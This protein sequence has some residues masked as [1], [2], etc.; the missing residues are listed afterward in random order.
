MD[1]PREE[2]A[3]RLEADGVVDVIVRLETE[4]SAKFQPRLGS[5]CG[6]RFSRTDEVHVRI[7]DSAALDDLFQD[8]RALAI[9]AADRDLLHQPCGSIAASAGIAPRHAPRLG[10]GGRL[11]FTDDVVAPSG[12][13]AFAGGAEV[14]RIRTINLN[15]AA[16][17]NTAVTEMCIS[18][19]TT[20][21]SWRSFA[22]SYR[23]SLG[24]TPGMH[25]VRVWYR[26]AAG[27][28]SDPAVGSVLYDPIDPVDGALSVVGADGALTANWSGFTDAL[29]GISTYQLRYQAGT[30]APGCTSGTEAYTGSDDSVAL[31]GLTNGTTYSFRL[32]AVDGAGNISPG[33]TATGR[34][35]P[36][37]T[38]PTDGEIV[39]NGGAAWTNRNRLTVTP[40]ASD[41][42]GISSVCLSTSPTSCTRW[43]AMGESVRTTV[44]RVEGTATVYAWFRDAYG[45]P[46]VLPVSD[47]IGVDVTRP[48]D[49]TGAVT[50]E[51]SAGTAEIAWPEGSDA[52]SG[53]AG[54]NIYQV[55]GT[56]APR[57]CR[58]TPVWTGTEPSATITGLTDGRTYSWRVCAVDQAG[59]LSLGL[60]TSGRPAPE[61]DAP[62]GTEVVINEGIGFTRSTRV[63]VAA[64]GEDPSGLGSMCLSNTD[65]CSLWVPYSESR[66][67]NITGANGEKVVKVWLRDIYGNA[68]TEPIE[69]S[70]VL[71]TVAPTG[72][73][74]SAEATPAPPPWSPGRV[75]RMPPAR[76]SPTGWSGP[77][78]PPPPATASPAPL[79]TLA[80]KNPA[81]SVVFVRTPP[82]PSASAP[83]MWPATSPPG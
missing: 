3:G 18:N 28:V 41:D 25:T 77:K 36:E 65:T 37:Y 69:G 82:T 34:P 52:R 6:T 61:Y 13:L 71:D 27:N 22:E 9:W 55:T 57:S 81:P 76:W 63:T 46:T 45:N 20:C 47:T 43:L 72:G 67:W 80:R 74:A 75:L 7:S 58:G 51:T 16:A 4:D 24:G 14:T 73:E 54:Y 83:S 70:I 30:R 48:L 15:L 23:W 66:T 35:A 50:I 42:S 5:R 12:T 8:E 44:P 21:T 60:T 11:V 26:D 78:A 33:A 29:S 19:S 1:T 53:V 68:M 56:R 10:E 49:G 59:N 39:I 32:C 79:A 17:D 62:V 38:P 40:S 31:S 2:L 64:T